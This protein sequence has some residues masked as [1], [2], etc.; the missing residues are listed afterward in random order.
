MAVAVAVTVTLPIVIGVVKSPRGVILP[1]LDFQ[2]NFGCETSARP[3]WSLAVAMNC[4]VP[5]TLMMIDAGLMVT[6]VNDCFTATFTE[7]VVLKPAVSAM[8]T[9]NL[10]VPAAPSVAVVFLAALVA[11]IENTGTEAPEGM[12]A[13]AQVY[14]KFAAPRTSVASAASVTAVPVTGLGLALAFSTNFGGVF[15]GG[16]TAGLIELRS[17][18]TPCPVAGAWLVWIAA[19][20]LFTD[21]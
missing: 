13:T 4:C 8:L 19:D 15:F 12:A 7:L 10:Y 6:L 2:V 18:A 3:N 16:V 1:P 14:V 5:P 9:V 21:P 11:L 17:P 20:S